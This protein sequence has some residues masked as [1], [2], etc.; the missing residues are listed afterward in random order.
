M[1]ASDTPPIHATRR[2]RHDFS[3]RVIQNSRGPI[4]ATETGAEGT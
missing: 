1:I 2:E 4:A 3:S